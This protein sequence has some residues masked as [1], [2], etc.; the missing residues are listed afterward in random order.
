M[1]QNPGNLI[2]IIGGIIL[3]TDSVFIRLMSIPNSWLIVVLRG[4]CMWGM[5]FAV[6]LVWQRSRSTIG[7]PWLTRD[8]WLSALF[9]CVASA[10]FVNA[11]N[12]GNIATVLV[13]I[14]STPF[15]SALISRLFFGVRIDRSLMAAA[16]AGIIGVVIVMFGKSGD[17]SAVANAF[18]LATA[19]SMALAF[20]FSSKVNSGTV[21][22]PS[23]GGVLASL[24]IM[25][26]NGKQMF[27]TSLLLS[28]TQWLWVVVEGA[29]IMPLAMGL[30]ALSTRFVSPANAG[31]FLLLET[32]LAPLWIYLFLGEAPAPHALVGGVIIVAA[33]ISQS[34]YSR[35]QQNAARYADAG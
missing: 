9:F 30:I 2:G 5:F 27:D 28:D 23:L 29:L 21:G 3:S 1:K 26:F 16:L 10:C 15:I 32:A 31:L 34:L 4:L 22:L 19:V 13:I 18:A 24:L 6:W 25:A 7:T 35:R 17:Q 11:L 8:N 14:S 12:R 33:V 20:I